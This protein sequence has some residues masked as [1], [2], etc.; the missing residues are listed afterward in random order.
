MSYRVDYLGCLFG[1]KGEIVRERLSQSAM[2]TASTRRRNHMQNNVLTLSK[3]VLS[4]L[5]SRGKTMNDFSL[6]FTPEYYCFCMQNQIRLARTVG[7]RPCQCAPL[8]RDLCDFATGRTNNNYF[9]SVLLYWYF[10]SGKLQLM[11]LYQKGLCSWFFRIYLL[12]VPKITEVG[13]K[14]P[15]LPSTQRPL[16]V[17]SSSLGHKLTK[18]T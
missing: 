16:P 3:L 7:W 6:S 13:H 2:I 14:P 10:I 17:S 5:G 15:L 8:P 4:S 12:Q 1:G 9:S 18:R 11:P